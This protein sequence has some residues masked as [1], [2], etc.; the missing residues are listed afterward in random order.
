MEHAD[1]LRSCA[2][3][4][5]QCRRKPGP[6]ARGDAA[7][8]PTGGETVGEYAERVGYSTPSAAARFLRSRNH[9]IAGATLKYRHSASEMAK[10]V[11][12]DVAEISR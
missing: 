1:K 9:K 8:P 10:R 2:R 6:K 11:R 3:V 7:A 12:E 4:I 5:K